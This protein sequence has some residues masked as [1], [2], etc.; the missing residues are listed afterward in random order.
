MPHFFGYAMQNHAK[1]II[2]WFPIIKIAPGPEGGTSGG[3]R[4]SPPITNIRILNKFHTS[5]NTTR[6]AVKGPP[7]KFSKPSLADHADPLVKFAPQELLEVSGSAL[8]YYSADFNQRLSATPPNELWGFL[9]SL[10]FYLI[11]VTEGLFS[12]QVWEIFAGACSLSERSS[13][14][15]GKI[16]SV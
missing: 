9:T 12:L 15:E 16:L 4:W 1:G 10:S 2:L 8:L 5:K 14:W 13:L 7:L 11:C 3:S 6:W